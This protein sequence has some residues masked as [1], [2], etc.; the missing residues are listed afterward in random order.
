MR[1]DQFTTAAQQVLADAQSA[2]ARAGH[3][4]VTGLPV[5]N[6][7]LD[8]RSGPAA[9]ILTKAGGEVSRVQVPVVSELTRLP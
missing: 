4:E 9:S 7:L 3:P 2:A 8:D 1:Q 6:A 5:L